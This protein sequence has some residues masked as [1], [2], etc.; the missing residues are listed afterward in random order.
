MLSEHHANKTTEIDMNNSSKIKLINEN[1]ASK[2]YGA[3][4]DLWD[5]AQA[6]GGRFGYE[7]QEAILQVWH[8]AHDLKAVV[9]KQRGA[10][11]LPA[12]ITEVRGVPAGQLDTLDLIVRDNTAFS[13]FFAL[14]DAVGYRP[15]IPVDKAWG[16]IL[17]DAY[18]AYHKAQAK[19]GN[20]YKKAF[21]YGG[22]Q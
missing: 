6:V 15:S 2:E 5:L 7:H 13:D 11:N 17:A 1:G 18:D 4:P 9:E 3:I 21:R 8:M 12:Q 14:I 22:G 16:M 10:S 20:S 19:P